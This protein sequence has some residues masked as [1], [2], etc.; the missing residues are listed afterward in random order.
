MAN[1]LIIDDDESVSTLLETQLKEEGH[2][3]K[4]AHDGQSGMAQLLKFK[5]DL[6][7]LDVF[8]PDSTGFQLC[9]QLR[10][11][12]LTK[13]TPIIMMTGAARF[14][15]Q[16]MIGYQKGANEYIF[17][18]F[19]INEVDNLIHKY[20]GSRKGAKKEARP[21]ELRFEDP[22]D[23][24]DALADVPAAPTQVLPKEEVMSSIN[25]FIQNAL[26]HSPSD[27]LDPP[28]PIPLM[29]MVELASPEMSEPMRATVPELPV[30]E[31]LIAAN[32]FVPS[33]LASKERFVDFGM[34]IM[35]LASRLC[36]NQAE[37]HIAEQLL[38]TS[39][40][41]SQK[42]TE[43]RQVQTPREYLGLLQ[44]ALK[45]I[46]ETSYWLML[47][48]KAGILDL[49]KRGEHYEKS[50]QSLTT[51]LADFV[52]SEKKRLTA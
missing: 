23:T 41:V 31:S 33:V 2:T 9:G 7:M 32:G 28:R 17:K 49:L 19:N 47:V 50:C 12:D 13:T 44:G 6:I 22:K 27:Q 21:R 38:R 51:L 10:K 43:S 46:R 1:V 5:P 15:T 24:L 37:K 39:L 35:G 42:L 3:V 29:P 26:S 20:I 4:I 14:S 25:Q 11:H 30:E 8:L 48:R 52:A 40:G 45:D 36:A 16:Q 18:P 34:E